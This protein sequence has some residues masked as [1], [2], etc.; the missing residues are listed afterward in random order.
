MPSS[1]L[2]SSESPHQVFPTLSP[3]VNQSAF[4]CQPA[5]PSL[6]L[7]SISHYAGDPNGP[8]LDMGRLG[9]GAGAVHRQDTINV[10]T[11]GPNGGVDSRVVEVTDVVGV[12]DIFLPSHFQFHNLSFHS[13]TS[14]FS[15]PFPFSFLRSHDLHV[16]FSSPPFHFSCFSFRVGS[17][18][19][20]ASV[21]FSQYYPPLPSLPSS[22]KFPHD[23]LPLAALVFQPSLMT[24]PNAVYDNNCGGRAARPWA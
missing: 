23:Q 4:L 2:L 3:L 19:P 15:N 18:L 22:F 20:P 5:L 21:P 17:E 7:S 10:G 1:T 6:S 9:G 8:A 14:V 11:R 16:L 13:S 24:T 12:V